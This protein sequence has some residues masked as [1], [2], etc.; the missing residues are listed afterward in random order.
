MLLIFYM[1]CSDNQRIKQ[2]EV[3]KKIAHMIY[4]CH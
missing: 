1:H 4:H 3:D 2:N